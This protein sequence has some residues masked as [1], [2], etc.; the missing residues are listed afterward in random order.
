MLNDIDMSEIISQKKRQYIINT[1]NM[2][3]LFFISIFYGYY[4]Y[5]IIQIS[6]E[7]T[8]EKGSNEYSNFY[9]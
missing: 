5:S 2:Y 6:L 7:L 3:N 8:K 4:T 9:N 1:I